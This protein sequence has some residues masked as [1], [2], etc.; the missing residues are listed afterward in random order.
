MPTTADRTYTT[1]RYMLELGGFGAGSVDSATGGYATSDVVEEKLSAADLRLHKHLAGVKYDPIAL[2]CGAGMSNAFYS[3]LSDVM[4]TKFVRKDGAVV[5]TDYNLREL[6]RLNFFNAL[7]TE[8]GFPALDGAS[9]DAAKLTVKLAPEYTRTAKSAGTTGGKADLQKQKRWLA[10]NF[11]LKIDGID[12]TRVNRVEPLLIE[13]KVVVS[14]TGEARFPELEPAHIEVPDLVVT[15]AEASAA[16]FVQ[17]H[18]DFVVNGNNDQAHERSGTLELLAPDMRTTLFTIGFGGLGIYK[19]V[20][21][22]VRSGSDGLRRIVASMYCE[23]M[24]FKAGSQSDA[25]PGADATGTNGDRAAD[26]S[27]TGGFVGDTEPPLVV[28]GGANGPF[29]TQD[30]PDRFTRIRRTT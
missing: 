25:V 3:W 1:S 14:Q 21:E 28:V 29:V 17:W 4:D 13:Q 2:E 16:D 9:K 6:S 7:V 26:A 24:T 27:A 18:D 20:P 30:F 23:Q 5:T 15:L 12:C 8:V 22:P 19:V 11:R 10:S